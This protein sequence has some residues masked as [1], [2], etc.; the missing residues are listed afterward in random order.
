MSKFKAA[1]AAQLFLLPPSVE[2]YV[3][4]GHLARLIDEVV[5][6]LD[7][8]AIEAKYSLLGQKSYHP[9]LLIKLLFYGYSRG[10]NSGR[11]I[12]SLCESDTAYMYLARQYRPDFR[13]INDFRKNNIKSIETFFVDILRM[14]VKLG[15]GKVGSLI[16]DSTKLRANASGNKS[17]DKVGYQRWQQ[18]L[19]EQIK[20][21]LAQGVKEDE[22]EDEIFG[23][24]R[25]DELPEEL[26]KKAS[27]KSKIQQVLEELKK[28]DE[29]VNL[30]DTDAKFIKDKS[31][32]SLNYSCQV[33]ITEDRL[34]VAAYATNEASDKKQL[35]KII[36]HAEKNVQR[37]FNV[38]LADSGYA[39]YDNYQWLE[40]KAK[41]AYIPDQE[42]VSEKKKQTNPY[43]RNHFIYQA[44]TDCYLCPQG[45]PLI[46]Q[47]NYEN[48][49][50]KQQSRIFQ[51]TQCHQCQVKSSCTSAA[52]RTIHQELREHLRAKA[53]SNLTSEQGKKLYGKRKSTIE[54][55]FGNLKH[56]LKYRMFQ[57][58][59]L[60][61]VNSE[62]LLMCI[63]HNLK[64]IHQIKQVI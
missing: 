13:T 18:K 26:R 35:S 55:V 16:M 45:K 40:E 64:L 33:G 50:L 4:E 49:K 7:T 36:E 46:F 52:C 5:D 10:V 34:I 3:P 31:V 12:A 1:N 43:H 21:G 11:K 56:N 6:T 60:L 47:S 63:A 62:F 38:V 22:E 19:S 59:G 44:Q 24:N 58:R 27:L 42:F 61:K 15:L 51:G 32:L 30:T 39:S 37:N 41:T 20:E 2:D 17:R 29:K 54:S 48:K 8:R 14:C 28:E 23:E 25:G 57:L 53:R 9:K